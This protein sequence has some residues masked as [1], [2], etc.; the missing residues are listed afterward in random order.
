MSANNDTMIQAN[1]K[2]AKGSLFNVYG[3][4]EASFDLGLAILYDRLATFAEIEQR[5]TAVDAVAA[6]MPLHPEQPLAI[7]VAPVQQE[8]PAYAPPAL[9]AAPAWGPP[10][11]PVPGH[12][13]AQAAIP[14]CQHGQRAPRSGASAK[15]PWKAWFCPTPKGTP[16]QCDATWVKQGTPEWSAFPA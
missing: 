1:F 10:A 16:G 3:R 12:T 15:G 2:S 11:A 7:H 6:V 4:D 5:L 9:P 13:F 14:S 8:Q